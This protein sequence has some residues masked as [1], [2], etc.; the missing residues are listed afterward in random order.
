MKSLTIVKS[1]FRSVVFLLSCLLFVY[2]YVAASVMFWGMGKRG[3][4]GDLRLD[5]PR[6]GWGSG[7]RLSASR[8]L[9]D[10]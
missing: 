5:W 3:R 8:F 1:S 10:I 2:L 4:G 7:K 9:C 6:E